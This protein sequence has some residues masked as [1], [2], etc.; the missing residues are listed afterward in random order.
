MTI[1]APSETS[2]SLPLLADLSNGLR[3]LFRDFP[4]QVNRAA[5]RQL[6]AFTVIYRD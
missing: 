4:A 3:T 2:A 1:A 6:H 5:G